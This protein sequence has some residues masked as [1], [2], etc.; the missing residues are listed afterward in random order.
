MN[1]ISFREGEPHM[2]I[3][4]ALFVGSIAALLTAP[5]LAKN[6][7][8][9]KME[10]DKSAPPPCHASIPAINGPGTQLPCEE[11]G[12]QAPAPRKPSARSAE[13]RH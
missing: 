7:E 4:N 13:V 8:A 2:R 11:V 10:E 12:S 6:S 1:N 5:V 9:Q 3:A